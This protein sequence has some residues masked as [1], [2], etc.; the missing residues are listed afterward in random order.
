MAPS[1]TEQ[2][3]GRRTHRPGRALRP[4]RAGSGRRRWQ[5]HRCLRSGTGSSGCSCCRRCRPGKLGRGRETEMRLSPATASQGCIPCAPQSRDRAATH[6]GCRAGRSSRPG[7][8]SRCPRRCRWLRSGSRHRSGC[9]RGQTCAP[10]RLQREALRVRTS[11]RLLQHPGQFGQRNPPA[12]AA[13]EPDTEKHS[14]GPVCSPNKQTQHEFLKSSKQST[15]LT[16]AAKCPPN[17]SDSVCSPRASI[18]SSSSS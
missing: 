16:A 8:G 18:S 2:V 14:T 1:T 7:S 6:S 17:F 10:G 9:S 3:R 4:R 11:L 13:A 12:E 5:G 15:A